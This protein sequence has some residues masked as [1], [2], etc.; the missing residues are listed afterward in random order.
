ML[1]NSIKKSLSKVDIILVSFIFFLIFSPPIIPQIN[2]ALFAAAYAFVVLIVKYRKELFS[3]IKSSGMLRF[4]II[5]AV[6]LVYVAMVTVVNYLTIGEH[7]Q[8]MHYIKLWY[9]F[10]MIVP[11]LMRCCL[12]IFLRAKELNYNLYDC[13]LQ[14][15]NLHLSEMLLYFHTRN[16]YIYIFPFFCL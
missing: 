5:F 14:K 8:L 7:V 2:T 11:V 9:R 12:F 4:G 13:F 16:L 6:F 10:F 3:A 1:L 15:I